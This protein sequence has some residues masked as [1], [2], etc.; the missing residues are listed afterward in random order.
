MT[1][2]LVHRLQEQLTEAHMRL[3]E[4]TKQIQSLEEKVKRADALFAESCFVAQERDQVRA[5]KGRA[6]EAAKAA[7]AKQKEAER[8]AARA[9]N[10]LER[11]RTILAA[12]RADASRLSELNARVASAQHVGDLFA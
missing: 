2:Q 7:Q 4:Y 11:E 8:E 6:Q 1:E 9:R 12:V 10:E 5:E 3:G